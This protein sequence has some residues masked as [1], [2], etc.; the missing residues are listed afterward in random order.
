MTTEGGFG[1]VR[2]VFFFWWYTRFLRFLFFPSFFTK[3]LCGARCLYNGLG[4]QASSFRLALWYSIFRAHLGSFSLRS[5]LFSLFSH[6]LWA[7]FSEMRRS[8]YQNR[9][10]SFAYSDRVDNIFLFS[11]SYPV[12]DDLLFSFF[13][14]PTS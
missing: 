2:G 9:E 4:S 13:A 1:G 11:R 3:K 5:A 6:L 14:V 7:F 12:F 8:M 10:R